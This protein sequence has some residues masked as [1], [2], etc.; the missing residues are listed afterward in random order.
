MPTHLH[1]LFQPKQ[2]NGRDPA[3]RYRELPPS[4]M[5][6]PFVSCY[7]Q[8]EPA[9]EGDSVREHQIQDPR[10]NLN[11][12]LRHKNKPIDRV[13]PDGCSDILFSHDLKRGRYSV[14]FC[15][16]SDEPFAIRYDRDYPLCNFGIRFFPGAAYA[17][18]GLPLGELTNTLVALDLIWPGMTDETASRIFAETSFRGRV[19]IA[20]QFLLS[21]MWMDGAGGENQ[22]RNLLHRILV[23]G[24]KMSVRELAK[25]EVISARQMNRIFLNRIGTSPKKFSEIVRFQAVIQSI[26]NP[27]EMDGASLALKHGY[28]DQAHMIREFKRYYGCSPMTAVREFGGVSD[29]YNTLPHAAD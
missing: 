25:Q 3:Y 21:A 19:H 7:W 15:G 1:T 29:F 22:F 20:E 5:L 23:S 8:S 24:G 4:P 9:G 18:L 17:L 26:R 14:L 16:L 12:S 27:P 13:I 10:L 6:A 28:F 11:R 2:A